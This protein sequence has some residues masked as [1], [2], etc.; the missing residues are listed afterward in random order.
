MDKSQW[1][2]SPEQSLSQ[3][4]GP[5]SLNE[6]DEDDEISRLDFNFG[7]IDAD[8]ILDDS[9]RTNPRLT[10]HSGHVSST[11]TAETSEGPRPQ[12]TIDRWSANTGKPAIMTLKEQEKA[13]DDLKKESLNLKLKVFFL[14]DRLAKLSPEHVEQALQEN[15]ELKVMVQNMRSELKQYKKLLM[16]SHA[17]IEALQAQK[18]CNLQHGMSEEQ[19]EEY[20]NAIAEGRKLRTALEHLSE[21]I[22][23]LEEEIKSKD[24]ALEQLQ[25][26]LGELDMQ[27]NTIEQLREM[28][29]KYE[30]QIEEL[31]ARLHDV[32]QNESRIL[33]KSRLD[34]DWDERCRQ[35]ERELR[36]STDLRSRLEQELAGKIALEEDLNHQLEQYRDELAKTRIDM[37]NLSRQLEDEQEQLLQ[38][39]GTHGN[40]MNTLSEHWTSERQQ[41]RQTISG[42]NLDIEDLQ[43]INEQLDIQAQ[44]LQALREDDHV[45]HDM[46]LADLVGELKDKDG[47]LAQTED[48]LR[49]A[50]S[51]LQEK[52]TKISELED[53]IE[54]LEFA[55]RDADAVH[56]E[57]IA[58]MRSNMQP[59]RTSS[60]EMISVSQH[61]FQQM[62]EEM[63]LMEEENRRLESL[64]K[65]EKEQRIAAE[66]SIHNRDTGEYEQWKEEQ[67]QLERDYVEQIDDLQGKLAAASEQISDL[68]NELNGRD[69]R[70]HFYEGELDLVSKQ[71]KETKESHK[72]MKDKLNSELEAT[73]A[74]F[75]DIR[76]EIEQDRASSKELLHAKSN[77]VDRL[78]TKSRDLTDTVADFEQDK[79]QLETDLRDRVTA[80]AALRLRMADLELKLSQKQRNDDTSVE[81]SKS[82]LFER[83]SL[84]FKVLL[85]LDNVL[86]GDSRL[87]S[88]MLPKPSVSF[89]TFS[90]YL[91]ARLILL[92]DLA[93]MFEKKS[94]MLEDKS[95]SQLI[96]MR[97]QLDL[98]LSQLDQFETIVRNAAD[99]QRKWREQLLKKQAENEELQ[100]KQLLLTKTI[101]ELRA[102]SGSGERVQDY[103]LKLHSAKTRY[104]NAEERWNARLRELE[105]RTKEA[106]ENVK[107]ERQGANEKLASLK[108]EN[109]NVQKAIENL[110]R[111]NEALQELVDVYKGDLHRGNLVDRNKRDSQGPS[112]PFGSQHLH[113]PG[114]NRNST[115]LGL[116]RMNDQLRS[117]LD[118]RSRVAEKEREKATSALRELESV[119][120]DCFKLQ[121]QLDQR[122]NVIKSAMSRIE[123]GALPVCYCFLDYPTHEAAG[124][125]ELTDFNAQPVD[126]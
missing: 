117:E 77:E 99:R 82:D 111:K 66:T 122:E 21:R 80:I 5:Y 61:N 91:N 106:E 54:Q 96:K 90:E 42:L 20:Q 55:R 94:R 62:S 86:G 24:S 8:I 26:R 75:L 93:A 2:A 84:L 43:K 126:A 85:Q 25:S 41:L 98:K 19:E 30:D 115:E 3:R 78:T 76:Q 116:S 124:A 118:Q 119:T 35:L 60:T 70:L 23:S 51:I 105:K 12:K 112:N 53:R 74:A 92:S 38:M 110:Q 67:Q 88:N 109:K 58:R 103:E 83:N 33:E 48:D 4:H 44:D 52:S 108:D 50:E 31:Q 15:V 27:A 89:N 16:E 29:A 114:H 63:A 6:D 79:Q 17:A 39:Q 34:E 28:S 56:D 69:Y 7:A 45:Q 18:N 104:A 72:D 46:E 87:D 73:T 22:K 65:I 95:M 113:N 36:A 102:R 10:A 32:Q 100:A 125:K 14:E 40:D 11:E 120:T 107:R 97:R 13:I 37:A 1:T 121:Q 81:N 64:L 101:V 49:D 9:I 59:G 71:L 57:V 123:V 47:E 68:H